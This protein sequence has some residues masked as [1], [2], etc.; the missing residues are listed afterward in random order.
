MGRRKIEIQPIT[1]SRRAMGMPGGLIVCQLVGSISTNGI[2]LLHF[3]RHVLAI[4]V[5]Y[6][7]FLTLFV[8]AILFLLCAIR[9]S[10]QERFVQK[11]LRARCSLFSRRSRRSLWFVRFFVSRLP[12][13]M[14]YFY[15]RRVQSDVQ[16]ISQSST[17]TALP[18]S[19]K[20]SNII[21]M[22]VA[23]L[24]SSLKFLI[25]VYVLA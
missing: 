16:D 7:L 15:H 18:I 22:F 8:L 12:P 1:V 6:S 23:S 2:V 5:S 21:F 17:S 11:G 14:I 24:L 3:K 25:S 10:A 19:K 9:R 4:Y 20:S 13:A